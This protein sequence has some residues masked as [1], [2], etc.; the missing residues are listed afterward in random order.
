MRPYQVGPFT[1]IFVCLA[2]PLNL[3]ACAHYIWTE[4]LP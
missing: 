2:V 3:I 4:I 1:K